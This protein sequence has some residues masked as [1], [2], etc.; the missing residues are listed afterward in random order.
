M[1][2]GTYYYVIQLKNGFKPVTGSVTI[3]R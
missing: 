2:V 3:I 1:P